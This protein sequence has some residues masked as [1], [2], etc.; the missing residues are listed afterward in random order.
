MFNAAGLES[1]ENYILDDQYQDENIDFIFTLYSFLSIHEVDDDDMEE[2]LNRHR[3]ATIIF[4]ITNKDLNNSLKHGS[5]DVYK[6]TTLCVI[7][8][9]KLYSETIINRLLE[10]KS[11][12]VKK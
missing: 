12:K 6:N 9:I 10:F 3:N 1:I 8:L 5:N 4:S 11:E 7:Y 2:L